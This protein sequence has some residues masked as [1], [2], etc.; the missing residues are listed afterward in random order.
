MTYSCCKN[1]YCSHYGIYQL[2]IAQCQ[3][4]FQAHIFMP[5]E[6]L[7]STCNTCGV[8]YQK[9]YNRQLFCGACH[10]ETCESSSAVKQ[11]VPKLQDKCSRCSKSIPLDISMDD[12]VL[13]HAR[14]YGHNN[15]AC[16]SAGCAYTTMDIKT[17]LEH[18]ERWGHAVTLL[19]CQFCRANNFRNAFLLKEH[20]LSVHFNYYDYQVR[21]DLRL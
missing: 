20:V 21:K 18:M 12:H 9:K 15:F 1:P 11:W 16:G 4:C 3:K 2:P 5:K 6:K 19:Y 10:D 13:T 17:L 7:L 14:E 8:T